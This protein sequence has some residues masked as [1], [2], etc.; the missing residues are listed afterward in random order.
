LTLNLALV[1]VDPS[2]II[3]NLK[4]QPQPELRVSE[5]LCHPCT[6]SNSKLDIACMSACGKLVFKVLEAKLTEHG[7]Q[8]QDTIKN[9][10]QLAGYMFSANAFSQWGVLKS[11]KSI[12]GLLVYPSAI[13]RLSL[14]KPEA[15][16]EFPIGLHHK[17]EYT[18]DPLMMGWFL[19]SFVRDYEADY[20]N[21]KQLESKL[22]FEHVDPTD[23]TCVNFKFGTPLGVVSETNLGFLFESDGKR[24]MRWK[25]CVSKAC[26]N[27]VFVHCDKIPVG[28]RL[29]VK[30]LSALS[31]SPPTQN[32]EPI[33]KLVDAHKTAKKIDAMARFSS[34]KIDAMA[35]ELQALKS[36]SPLKNETEA[37]SSPASLQTSPGNA[38]PSPAVIQPPPAITRSEFRFGI[39]HPYIGVIRCDVVNP[40]LIMR[41]VGASLAVMCADEKFLNK[42]KNCLDFRL[43]FRNDVGMSALNL[44]ESL[45]LV[46]NDIRLPNIAVQDDSFCL[47][48]FDNS[49][50]DVSSNAC[51][52]RVLRRYKVASNKRNMMHT[53]AQ[54]AVVVYALDTRANSAEVRDVRE[55]WL[56]N[57][58]SE[59][60]AKLQKSLAKFNAWLKC[61]GKL[62]ENV[63]SETVPPP[64]QIRENK[65]Y[66]VRVMD[67]MLA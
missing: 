2:S 61:K 37:K 6:M 48:D 40:F 49:R 42:W 59:P 27:F 9:L 3:C 54:I 5:V 23:W 39:K 66:F 50:D 47:I 55:Y 43:K 12:I 41:N 21:V 26:E 31:V 53:I 58:L 62:V 56:S 63:F 18:A 8:S 35:R 38:N 60:K 17:V 10:Q 1:Q 51:Q 67:S 32:C 14:S 36:G 22:D 57:C 64:N 29:I 4:T 44:V 33:I 15:S 16:T 20:L 52:S 34:Q 65:S 46:H 45:M 7:I 19:E 24:L 28:E 25:T 11:K 30:Y 13:Y